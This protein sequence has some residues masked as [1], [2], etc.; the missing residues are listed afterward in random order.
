MTQAFGDFYLQ[1]QIYLIIN[2]ENKFTSIIR[3]YLCSDS[4]LVLSLMLLK[5]LSNEQISLMLWLVFYFL[6]LIY[7][8][9]QNK[10]YIGPK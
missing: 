4:P 8:S 2:N 3:F 1:V 5:M 6:H 10:P 9:E 7:A